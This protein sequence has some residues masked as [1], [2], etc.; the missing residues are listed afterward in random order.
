[1]VRT[2]KSTVDVVAHWLKA[3]QKVGGSSRSTRYSYSFYYATHIKPIA[4]TL[5]WMASVK[6]LWHKRNKTS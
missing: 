6:W 5:Y 1:M 2:E 3:N 4:D